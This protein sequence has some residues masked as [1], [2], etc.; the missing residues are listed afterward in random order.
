[1]IKLIFLILMASPAPVV[2]Q[3]SFEVWRSRCLSPEDLW[4]DEAKNFCEGFNYVIQNQPEPV[5]SCPIGSG[6]MT[7]H[8]TGTIPGGT[9]MVI[10]N[11]DG[12]V[13]S[14]GPGTDSLNGNMFDYYN[15]GNGVMV[16]PDAPAT[17]LDPSINLT[18]WEGM[19]GGFE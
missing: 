1:M 17:L 6:I 4:N 2:A 8:L 3:V 11:D 5:F 14:T 16:M 10:I 15:Q 18:P 9:S 12:Q 13:L 7:G 19:S